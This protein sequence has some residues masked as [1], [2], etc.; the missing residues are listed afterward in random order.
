MTELGELAAVLPS[1]TRRAW[2]PVAQVTPPDGVL[3][4]GTALAVHLRHRVSRD[5]D[6]FITSDFDVGALRDQ[7]AAIGRFAVTQ[8]GEGTLNG[9]FEEAKVQFL[10]AGG[11]RVLSEPTVVAGMKVGAIEDLLA[12]KIK[13]VGDRAELRDYFDLMAIEQ[14]A[15]RFVEEGLQLY[16]RRY[17]VEMSHVSIEHIVLGFGYFDD[18]QDDPHLA[19][20]HGV[21]LSDRVARY[22]RRRQPEII[23]SLDRHIP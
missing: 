21:D 11:Q 8:I 5:L 18:L 22:W 10:A 14:H 2:G 1:A 20:E 23:A 4:G 6:V 15:G 7:L 19:S 9:V 12:T 16:A 17:G 3:M 13:V